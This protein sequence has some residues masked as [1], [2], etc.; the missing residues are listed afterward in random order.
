MGNYIFFLK[1]WN[2]KDDFIAGDK[3][4]Q[5]SGVNRFS[6][7]TSGRFSRCAEGANIT[8]V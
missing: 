8:Y 1:K 6:Q 3:N 2:L 4:L 5:K 7:N